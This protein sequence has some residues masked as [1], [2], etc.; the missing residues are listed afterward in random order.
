[1]EASALEAHLQTCAACRHEEEVLRAARRAVR[2]RPVGAVPDLTERIMQAVTAEGPRLR[3]RSE[4]NVRFKVA[5]VA[6]AASALV[7]AGATLPLGRNRV[8]VA[9]A[10]EIARGVSSAARAL[11]S[12]R[13]SYDIVERGFHPNVPVRKLSAEVWFQAPER[14]RMLISDFTSYPGPAWTRN[15]VQLVANARKWSIS[16]PT[17]WDCPLVAGRPCALRDQAP[18]E[19]RTIVDRQPFDG[20]SHLPTDLVVPL[21]T[22]VSSDGFHVLGRATI[23]G[24]EAHHI[25]LRYGAAIPLVDALQTGGSWRPLHPLDRVEL[26][27]DAATWF[28]L[29]FEVVASASPDRAVWAQQQGLHDSAGDE[30][31]SVEAASFE[32]AEA[33]APQTFRVPTRGLVKSGG[34]DP[35][36]DMAAWAPEPAYIA[37]LEPYRFG[38]S[39]AGEVIRSYVDGMTWLKVTTRLRRAAGSHPSTAELVALPAAAGWGYY[40]PATLALGRRVDVF[41]ERV[42]VHVESNLPRAE[43]MDVAASLGVTGTRLQPD[44]DLLRIDDDDPYD[45]APYALTPGFVP[46]GYE[47]TTALLARAA[48]GRSTLTTYYRGSEAD[49]SDVGVRITQSR[50]VRLLVPSSRDLTRVTMGAFDAR[51][52]PDLGQLEWIDGKTYRS[53]TVPSFDLSTA[54]AIAGSLE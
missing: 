45:R 35:A 14:F 36:R 2:I 32:T 13:A 7:L 22:L 21:E 1:N 51:W 15:N 49:Y 38:R 33:F 29:R 12:Y 48:D 43:L 41:G 26:W 50:P 6:A 20:T 34:F 28:P 25:A 46:R 9:S 42:Q 24:R 18:M 44:G 19:S 4:W 10:T 16:E 53:I 11:Q 31:L 30:L 37:G 8:D 3:R 5:A 17:D 47:L 40:Q 39:D 23:A 52:A 54:M 27:I